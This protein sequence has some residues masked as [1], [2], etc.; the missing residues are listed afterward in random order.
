MGM[1]VLKT[2]GWCFFISGLAVAAIGIGALLVELAVGGLIASSTSG[3]VL[4]TLRARQLGR[5]DGPDD[6]RPPAR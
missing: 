6:V 4:L 1:M 2:L 5:F 3:L